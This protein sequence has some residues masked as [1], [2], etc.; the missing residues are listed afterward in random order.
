MTTDVCV[1]I[2]RLADCIEETRADNEAAGVLAPMVGHVGDGN[3]HLVYVIDA[4]DPKEVEA[5]DALHE[6][7]VLRA[8]AMGG[9][10]TGEH[11]VGYG[12]MRFL[13]AEQ[14]E[15]VSLMRQVKTALD[16]HNL[17]NPGKVIRI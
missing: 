14:G 1:P 9:T 10:C 3:F 7:M 12:K 16:P 17:M 11:G 4:D 6:R 8:L 15:A 2:S 13:E 5:A